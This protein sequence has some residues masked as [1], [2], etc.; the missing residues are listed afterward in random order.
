MKRKILITG[1]N[2][3]LGYEINCISKMYAKEN[4]FFFANKKK[5]DITNFEKINEYIVENKINIIVNCAAYTNVNKA[6]VEMKQADL[7]NNKSVENLA[8]ISKSHNIKLI[9]ISTDYVYDGKTNKPYLETDKV[10]A[11]SIYGKTK[12]DG[13]SAFIRISPSNSI[14]IRTSWLYSSHGNNFVKTM[15]D[16]GKKKSKLNVV[17]D[18]I[19]APTYARDLAKVILDIIPKLKN[20]SVEVYNYSNEG[21]LSWYDFAKG[22]MEISNTNCKVDPIESKDYPL[23]EI[24]PYYSLLNKIKIKKTFNIEIPY[25]KDSLKKCLELL[26]DNKS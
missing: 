12:L 20:E 8:L 26:G 22:I 2:G 7:I 17:S 13:E 4:D 15:L 14:I 16:L 18:Q 1:A 9:H 3:Q 23:S 10:S 11:N 19:G 25:Y 21:A 24:R 5:L 6:E